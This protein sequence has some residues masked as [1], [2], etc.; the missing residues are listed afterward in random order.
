VLLDEALDRGL[1]NNDV[2][3]GRI[4]VLRGATISENFSGDVDGAAGLG[5]PKD[6]DEA[7]LIL[8]VGS[9]EGLVLL[10]LLLLLRWRRRRLSL[11]RAMLLT[12]RL[13]LLLLLLLPL[14]EK[15]R[16]PLLGLAVMPLLEEIL[17]SRQIFLRGATPCV[18][19]RCRWGLDDVGPGPAESSA[20][21]RFLKGSF[22]PRAEI[23]VFDQSVELCRDGDVR[24]FPTEVREV[25]AC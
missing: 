11:I 4:E 13:L 16:R 25:D 2:R 6:R 7:K 20:R 3:G 9:A 14:L 17:E 8:R 1:P 18:L 21:I 23:G 22:F 19:G 10:L 15:G 12:L 5:A 24:H